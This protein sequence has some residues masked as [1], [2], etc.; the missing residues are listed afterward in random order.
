[1]NLV[2][3]TYY[4]MKA[5]FR[6]FQCDRM[7]RMIQNAINAYLDLDDNDEI[8]K[9]KGLIDKAM[10]ELPSYLLERDDLEELIVSLKLNDVEWVGEY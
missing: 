3:R 6:I 2:K 1:M 8:V 10:S 7:I 5:R 9:F 4:I